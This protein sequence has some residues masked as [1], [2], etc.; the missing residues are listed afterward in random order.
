VKTLALIGANGMLATA[1]KKLLPAGFELRCY[2]LPE[3]DLRQRSQVFALAEAA[4]DILVNCAAFTNVDGCET[5]RELAFAV[6]GAGAGLLAE[7]ARQSGALLVHVSTDF[8]FG[9]DQQTPYRESDQPRPLS[10]Y[11]Q[12]KW[13]GEQLIIESG[14][15]RYFIIRTSWL[16][17]AGGGNFVETILRLAGEKD[18]L[19][20]VAD[21]R[22]TPT[23]TE[24]LARAIFSLLETDQYGIYHFSNS[25]ECSWYEFAT[26]IVAEAK[27]L[28]LPI[29]ATE[30]APIPT[31]AYPLPATRP[32]YSVLAKEKIL[33]VTGMAI[34]PWPVSLHN[35]LA[36]RAKGANCGNQ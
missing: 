25:G 17:G 23:W 32:S 24:D 14:L 3:F 4:P 20:I 35:Y 26:A 8:V 28:G 2:D 9:G 34:P 27:Q 10:V 21:Q 29:K 30:I 13:R 11:G 31:E 16:Y 33:A 12:S 15:E 5:E 36:Q 22:G 1:V 18:R 7:L 6:N 19:T